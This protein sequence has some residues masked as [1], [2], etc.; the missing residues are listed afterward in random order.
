LKYQETL[1]ELLAKQYEVAKI[2]ESKEATLIQVLDEALPPERKSKPKRTVLV[3]FAALVAGILAMAVAY[4]LETWG[5][6]KEQPEKREQIDSLMA[7]WRYSLVGV[8]LQRLARFSE[9]RRK[10]P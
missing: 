5:R 6:T 9:S 2:D 10:A 1:F 7:Q 8:F 3:L 4:G